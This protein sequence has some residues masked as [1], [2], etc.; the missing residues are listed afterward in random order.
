MNASTVTHPQIMRS[1]VDIGH[2][3]DQSGA[4]GHLQRA[5]PHPH[6]VQRDIDGAGLAGSRLI[7]R[8]LMSRTG[9][10]DGKNHRED[11]SGETH[12]GAG[13][14]WWIRRGGC[15]SSCRRT[16]ERTHNRRP[17]GL[18]PPRSELG[19]PQ[20]PSLRAALLVV[21]ADPAAGAVV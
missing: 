8:D 2:P 1:G 20:P 14:A 11:P 7:D 12:D 16:I 15:W 19:Q 9:Q 6:A 21:D 13:P 10:H 17:F 3:Q 4:G 18:A 5:R